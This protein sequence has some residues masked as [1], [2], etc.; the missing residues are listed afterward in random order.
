MTDNYRTALHGHNG[1]APVEEETEETIIA[2]TPGQ[3]AIVVGILLLAAL[4]LWRRHA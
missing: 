2:L 1:H 3:L 4:W